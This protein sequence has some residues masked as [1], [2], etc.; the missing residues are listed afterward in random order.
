M[1]DDKQT[2]PPE[3]D[4]GGYTYNPQRDR[5]RLGRQARDV[6][7]VMVQGGYHT[8]RAI[9]VVTGHP[10]CSISA[11]LRDFRKPEYGAHT[12]DR[13]RLSETRGTHVYRLIINREHEE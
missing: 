4:R 12:I 6:W 2:H 9:E 13:H 5:E 11:R 1:Y 8:L 10:Q 7:D 3:G